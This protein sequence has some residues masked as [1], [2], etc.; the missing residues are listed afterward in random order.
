MQMST[1][2][3]AHLCLKKKKKTGTHCC[4]KSVG[5]MYVG[6]CVPE[7]VSCGEWGQAAGDAGEHILQEDEQSSW[8]MVHLTEQ[9]HQTGTSASHDAY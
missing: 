4:Q 3:I 5:L 2:W 8:L 1:S 7:Y 9:T 6:V